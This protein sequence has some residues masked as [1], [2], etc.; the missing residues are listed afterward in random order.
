MENPNLQNTEDVVMCCL[1]RTVT[2]GR[3]GKE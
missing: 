2:H 1:V 3:E